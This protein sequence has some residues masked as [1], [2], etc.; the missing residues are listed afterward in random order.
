MSTVHNQPW[1]RNIHKFDIHESLECGQNVAEPHRGNKNRTMFVFF[2]FF[3]FFLFN[4]NVDSRK[5][6]FEV[7][8]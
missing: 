2:F 7:Q 6:Y 5:C 4:T 3:L 8:L 1:V